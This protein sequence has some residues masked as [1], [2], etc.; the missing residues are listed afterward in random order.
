[1]NY[2]PSSNGDTDINRLMDTAGGGGRR[3]WKAWSDMETCITICKIESQ[4]EFAIW[5]KELKLGLG[6]ILEGWDGEEGGRDVHVEGD[7]GKPMADSCWCLVETNTILKSNY[8]SI[9]NKM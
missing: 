3:G 9:K 1:M 8:P 2:L 6:N 5:L 7:M 4:W